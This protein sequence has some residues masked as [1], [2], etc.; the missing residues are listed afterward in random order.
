MLI[1]YNFRWP[2]PLSSIFTIVV[3]SCL[4]VVISKFFFKVANKQLLTYLL[5]Y[6]FLLKKEKM[7][8]TKIHVSLSTVISNGDVKPVFH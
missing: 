6:C 5:T 1:Y 3:V 4:F 7:I 8:R 2:P